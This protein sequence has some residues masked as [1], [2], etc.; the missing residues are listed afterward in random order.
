MKLKINI[1]DMFLNSSDSICWLKI[2]LNLKKL[3]K[4]IFK[5][6]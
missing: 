1:G 4:C 5:V 2:D 3:T 6:N